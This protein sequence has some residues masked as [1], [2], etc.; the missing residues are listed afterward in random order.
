MFFIKSN[1]YRKVLWYWISFKN[2]DA[3]T[4]QCTLHIKSQSSISTYN[5]YNIYISNIH[6]EKVYDNMTPISSLFEVLQRNF[7]YLYYVLLVE[8]F[9]R[10]L[11]WHLSLR[12][13]TLQQKSA[14]KKEEHKE[15]EARW[16]ITGQI[17]LKQFRKLT[18][19]VRSFPASVCMGQCLQSRPMAYTCATKWALH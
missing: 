12:N 19:L 9:A 6:T 16:W 1:I 3:F 15:S 2:T 14:F 18:S 7:C 10:L 8:R 13:V 5:K 17:C 4:F 11:Y